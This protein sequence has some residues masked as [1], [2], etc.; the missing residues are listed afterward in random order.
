MRHG[1]G[2]YGSRVTTLADAGYWHRQCPATA[3]DTLF[4][5]LQQPVRVQETCFAL[6][7]FSQKLFLLSLELTQYAVD[8]PFQLR[9]F[10]RNGTFHRL[11][12]RGMRWDGYE[13]ADKN[14]P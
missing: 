12:Q 9:A 10:N 14:P 6:G 1:C 13:E 11:S 3:V 5:A 4:Q 2:D 8:Q 7:K